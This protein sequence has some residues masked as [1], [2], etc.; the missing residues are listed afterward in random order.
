MIIYDCLSVLN[1]PALTSQQITEILFG[2]K[3]LV[4]HIFRIKNHSVYSYGRHNISSP[5]ISVVLM[6]LLP[7]MH[8]LCIVC[9]LNFQINKPKNYGGHR[10]WSRSLLHEK[11]E[12][13]GW[14][15]APF[16]S[17][18]LKIL[19]IFIPTY[20]GSWIN[21]LTTIIMVTPRVYSAFANLSTQ[22]QWTGENWMHSQTETATWL[23]RN[24]PKN[25]SFFFLEFCE[26]LTN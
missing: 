8:H 16:A 14:A 17:H 18:G 4:F 15:T 23:K 24:D 19:F 10:D 21:S 12:F 5:A 25:R 20:A 3:L 22:M 7:Y 6:P 9:V 11:W 13:Y 2:H 1:F 26:G